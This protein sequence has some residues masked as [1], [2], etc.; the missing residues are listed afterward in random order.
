MKYGVKNNL[1]VIH[2]KCHSILF[3]SLSGVQK[4]TLP[5]K[6]LGS[7]RFYVFEQSSF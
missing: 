6:S 1:G 7:V 3:M 5:F 4:H 2:E